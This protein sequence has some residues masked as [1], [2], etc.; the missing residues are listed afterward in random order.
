MLASIV[1][2]RALTSGRRGATAGLTLML[3]MPAWAAAE[4]VKT[5]ARAVASVSGA[6]RKCMGNSGRFLGSPLD[7]SWAGWVRSGGRG[8]VLRQFAQL[9]RAPGSPI[10][11]TAPP[12]MM[13]HAGERRPHEAA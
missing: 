1:T 12:A 3:F 13:D 8:R 7:A 5:A 4:T 11:R 6:R 10:S 9:P 2:G